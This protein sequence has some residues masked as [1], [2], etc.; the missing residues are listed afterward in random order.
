MGRLHELTAELHE[1]QELAEDG[2]D[3]ATAI[4]R[5]SGDLRTKATGIVFVI[6]NLES[7]AAACEAEAKRMAERAKARA[8]A[9]ERLK[10]YV[11]GTMQN[12]GVLRIE[13]HTVTLSVA[14]CPERVEVDDESALPPEF[15]REKVTKSP[16]KAAIMAAYKKHGEVVPGTHVVR[17]TRLAIK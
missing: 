14:Q 8:N 15:V 2:A 3:V 7:D 6:R 13:S 11:L 9:A 5:V 10:S 17:G 1:L 16:D 12:H 4:E